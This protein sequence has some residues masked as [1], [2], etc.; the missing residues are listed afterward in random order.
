MAVTLRF[1][2]FGVV[3]VVGVQS[4]ERVESRSRWVGMMMRFL[5]EK[6][7]WGRS[8]AA[9]IEIETGIGIEIEI[10]MIGKVFEARSVSSS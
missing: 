4:K 10:G 5:R 1:P 2:G 6:G 9:V 7:F 3:V 8:V